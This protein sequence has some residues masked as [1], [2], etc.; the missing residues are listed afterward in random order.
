MSGDLSKVLVPVDGSPPAERAV[1]HAIEMHKIGQVRELHL[2]NVQP[3]LSGDVATFVDKPT[4][5]DYHR[6][7]ADKA[8]EGARKLLKAAGVPIK[9]HIGVGQPA[10]TIVAFAKKLDCGQIV[11]GTHGLGAAL[12]LVLGSVA[13]EVVRESEAAVTVVK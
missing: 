13:Q 3:P 1:R 9:E 8:L 10:S 6:D 11:M 7:E 12:R 4:R 5:D 2:L